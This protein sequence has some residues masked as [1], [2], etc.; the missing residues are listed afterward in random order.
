M[1]LISH[2]GNTD[3]PNIDL[4][5]NPNQIQ[6]LLDKKINVEIDVWYKNDNYFLGHD[7]PTYLISEKFLLQKKLWCHA[8]NLDALYKLL[9]LKTV[10]FWHQE[11]NYTLT[12]NNYIWTY[13]NKTTNYKCI[14]VDIT[15]DWNKKKYNCAGICVDYLF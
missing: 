8:K 9:K 12:S 11:D 13:P 7:T 2:R 5:N 1:I 10:C 6:K 14:I 3:G 15:P 4:E